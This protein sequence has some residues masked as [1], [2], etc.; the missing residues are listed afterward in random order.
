MHALG[1]PAEFRTLFSN[2]KNT[3]MISTN[4]GT[5]LNCISHDWS[6]QEDVKNHNMHV[7]SLLIEQHNQTT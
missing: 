3:F 5:S 6:V 2:F 4:N 7:V 1:H